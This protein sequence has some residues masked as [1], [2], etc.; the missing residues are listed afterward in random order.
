MSHTSD[1][2]H[3]DDCYKLEGTNLGKSHSKSGKR[4]FYVSLVYLID[5]VYYS[6]WTRKV[7][8]VHFNVTLHDIQISVALGFYIIIAFSL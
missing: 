8:N 3:K 2:S 1:N 7:C 5:Y 4:D 6:Y